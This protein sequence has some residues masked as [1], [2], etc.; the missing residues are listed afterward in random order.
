VITRGPMSASGIL[1]KTFDGGRC[2]NDVNNVNDDLKLANQRRVLA[3]S[4]RGHDADDANSG[5]VSRC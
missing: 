2:A 3:R 1:D 4:V 5:S